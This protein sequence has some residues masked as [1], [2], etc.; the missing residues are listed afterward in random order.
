MKL[1]R[2]DMMVGDIFRFPL[3]L[4]T[5]CELITKNCSPA[6]HVFCFLFCRIW[7]NF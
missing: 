7:R 6:T 5:D 3:K 1:P 2:L 4:L